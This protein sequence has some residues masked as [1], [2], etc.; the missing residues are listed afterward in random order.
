LRYVVLDC[1]SSPQFLLNE[2]INLTE[3]KRLHV[4]YILLALRRALLRIYY[5][6]LLR[7][8]PNGADSRQFTQSLF[9]LFYATILLQILLEVWENPHVFR[10]E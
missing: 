4:Q 2:L 9:P 6:R 5:R 8:S 7:V 3:G 1:V 10:A